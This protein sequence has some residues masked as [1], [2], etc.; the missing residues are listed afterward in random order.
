MDFDGSESSYSDIPT[1][2]MRVKVLYSF[3]QDNKTNCLARFPNTLQ[4][5]AVAIDENSQVGV[6]ELRQ[7]LQAIV[8]ASPELLS[9]LPDGDFTVYAYDYSEYETPLV[10]QGMLS[11]ALAAA[12]PAAGSEETRITGRICKN[13]PALFSNGV[14][15]T[16][17]VKLRLVPVARPAQTDFTRSMESFRGVS[18]ATSAGF[19]PNAWNAS[20]NQIRPQQVSNDYFNFDPAPTASEKDMALVDEMFGLASTSGG[21]RSGAHMMGGVGM[22]QT[23]TDPAFGLNP[24]FS[25]SAPGSRMGSPMMGFESSTQNDQLRHQS[26]STNAQNFPDQSRPG[27]RASVRSEVQSPRHQRQ[28]SMQSNQQQ[29]VHPPTEGYYNEDGQSRKRAKVTQADWR[30]RSSFGAKSGD[31]R[32]TAAAAHSMHMHRPI[33]KRSAAPGSD[34]EPPPRVPT[35][36]PQRNPMLPRQGMSQPMPSRS[37]LRQASTATFDSDF[38]SDADHYSDALM[39]SPEEGSPNNSI[40][41]DG[42][43]LDIPSSPP[44]FNGTSQPQPSSPGLPALPVPRMADSGYMSERGLLSSNFMNDFEDDENRS[45]D[46]QDLEDAAQYQARQQQSQSFVKSEGTGTGMPLYQSDTMDSGMNVRLEIPGDMDQLPHKMLLSGRH[47]QESQGPKPPRKARPSKKAANADQS[48]VATPINDEQTPRPEPPQSRR[49]SLALPRVQ[50]LPIADQSLLQAP[51]QKPAPKRRNTK[52][53]RADADGS[54]AGSPAPSDTEGGGPRGL[55]RSGS[56]AQRRVIIQQRLEASLAKGD[57][58][59]FCTHCGAIETPTWRKLYTKEVNGKPSALDEAEGEGETIG[60][61]SLGWDAETREV[62]RFIIRKSMK[63]TKECLPEKD[64]ETVTVC[65]PCGL[66]FNKYRTMRPSDKWVKR[67]SNRRTKKKNADGTDVPATDGLEPQSEAFFT[68]QVEPGDAAGETELPG[69]AQL[70]G[71]GETADAQQPLLSR[72]RA[73]SLQSAR[74]MSGDPSQNVTRSNAALARAVQSSPIRFNGSQAS[75]IEIEDITPKPTRRLLFPSPRREGEDKA[76]DDNDQ[77]SLS[78]TPPPG[79]GSAQ[80]Q[81]LTLKAGIVL[82][83]A[84]VNIFEAFT[85]DKENMA[86]GLDVDDDDLAHLFEGSPSALFKTPSKT[87]SKAAAITP[88]SQRQLEHLLKTPTPASRK[89]R[90]LSPSTH[91]NAAINHASMPANDFMTSPSSSR[92]FLRS[93]PSRQDRTPGRRSLS[94][95]HD[96]NVDMTPF[97]RHLAQM[98]SDANDSATNAFPSPSQQAFDF[99]DLPT[100][101]TPGRNLSEVDWN[102]MEDILSSEFAAFEDGKGVVVA[103]GGA[104]HDDALPVAEEEE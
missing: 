18:P 13:I 85:F 44:V 32:V 82:E 14:K 39:S 101:T 104:V 100:F 45:P 88:R 16:L 35:P 2:P 60:V 77:A 5:P 22:A 74:P 65:N 73:N 59:A 64:F 31:L 50:V 102:G 29:P 63:K 69:Q 93:T 61:E 46:A 12:P 25:H 76:L 23:P 48:A 26:F 38:M 42:T 24:A 49:S 41:A 98:L 68:D 10:G 95:Q 78:A 28:A 40:T 94:G 3:D 52:R 21:S 57:L 87:P 53:P 92:Y 15:E 90:P 66:W 75:P 30:G 96:R 79:K 27:S 47:R 89:R 83:C 56:G 19:D 71:V 70:D 99:S 91:T 58:P 54:E 62:T 37:L 11:A 33:A 43:P 80:K 81:T 67:T 6:I 8:S 4:I 84:D 86:P 55:K 72:P 1:R 103:G 20:Y 34:L 36:V 17:E 7:C 9:R 51:H 97:S